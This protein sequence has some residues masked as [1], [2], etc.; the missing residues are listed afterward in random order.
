MRFA[1]LAKGLYFTRPTRS[2][3]PGIWKKTGARTAK[4]TDGLGRWSKVQTLSPGEPVK[5]WQDRECG[6]SFRQMQA[7]ID[8]N[9][10]L[11]L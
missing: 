10:E 8:V 1:Q 2:D 5:P 4:V 11:G 3:K 6:L 9:L 7:T